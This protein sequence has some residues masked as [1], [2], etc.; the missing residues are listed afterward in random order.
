MTLG[1]QKLLNTTHDYHH[2]QQ[3]HAKALAMNK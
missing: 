3:N 2:Y 1:S